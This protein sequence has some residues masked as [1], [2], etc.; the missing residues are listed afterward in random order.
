M[1]MIVATDEIN[2]IKNKNINNKLTTPGTQ[3]ITR[4]SDVTEE[5]Q[6]ECSVTAKNHQ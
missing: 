5:P 1:S 4:D 3:N 2:Y 6:K